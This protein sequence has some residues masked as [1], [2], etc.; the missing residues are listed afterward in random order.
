[1]SIKK[2][3]NLLCVVL[4]A[5][6]AVLSCEDEYAA[7]ITS[8]RVSRKVVQISSKGDTALVSYRLVNPYDGEEVKY[9]INHPERYEIQIDTMRDEFDSVI[10]VID[11]IFANTNRDWLKIEVLEEEAA[12]AFIASKNQTDTM[13]REATVT[14]SYATLPSID[15]RVSQTFWVAPVYI[16]D[17]IVYNNKVVLTVATNDKNYTWSCGLIPKSTFGEGWSDEDIYQY[18]IA[19]YQEAADAEGKTIEEYLDG[20]YNIKKS[21]QRGK[22]EY[23]I[24]GLEPSTEYVVY[25]YGLNAL[26]S[27]TSAVY[28]DSFTT[29]APGEE[30]ELEDPDSGVGI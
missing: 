13:G 21:P 20:I 1:M 7:K 22:N 18:D 5:A 12:V 16:S 8:F 24:E 10:V 28:L 25:L 29:L 23:I 9:R 3:L 19:R 2:Y 26:G 30:P 11:T 6:A 15:I 17:K 4:L 27:R 14:L